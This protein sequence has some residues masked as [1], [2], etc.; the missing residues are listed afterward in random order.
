M[1]ENKHDF[2]STTYYLMLKKRSKEGKKS[3]A[4]LNSEEFFE[5]LK[6]SDN[7]LKNQNKI[8][9]ELIEKADKMLFSLI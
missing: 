1:S 7:M 5:F 2:I 6:N 9:L 3:V 4:D 8:E